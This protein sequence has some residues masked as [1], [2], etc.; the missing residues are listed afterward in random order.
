MRGYK[1]V[2]DLLLRRQAQVNMTDDGVSVD[3]MS[4]LILCDMM[5]LKGTRITVERKIEI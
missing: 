3:S 4:E 2:V 1:S 5:T